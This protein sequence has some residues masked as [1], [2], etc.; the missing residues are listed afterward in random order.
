MINYKNKCN[1]QIDIE[2]MLAMIKTYLKQASRD[3]EITN[4]YVQDAA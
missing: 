3:L 2:E 1:I 4:I